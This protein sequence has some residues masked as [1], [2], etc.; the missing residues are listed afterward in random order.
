MTNKVHADS[1]KTRI[2]HEK[3][4]ARMNENNIKKL[5]KTATF[6]AQ[7]AVASFLDTLNV[8]ADFANKSALTNERFDVYSIDSMCSILQFALNAISIDSLKTN[9]AEVIQTAIKLNDAELTFTQDDAV[10]AL[11]KSMKIADKAKASLI[12]R[13]K[14]H[15][16]SAK[17]HAQMTINAMLALRALE[18]T[19]K[20]TYK[21][22]DN[23]LVTRLKERF[24]AL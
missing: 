17:R 9:V 1:L 8:E 14:T 12:V 23:E 13:R 16:D 18:A 3:S 22:A 2:A 15:F 10:C 21:L 11:D 19:A 20:N 24:A 5:E 7:D 6:F 4:A